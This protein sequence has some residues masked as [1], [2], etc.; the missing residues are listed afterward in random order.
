MWTGDLINPTSRP[1]F[2]RL[3]GDKEILILFLNSILPMK[4][5]DA[6]EIPSRAINK[7]KESIRSLDEP[8]SFQICEAFS[9]NTRMDFLCED[10][11]N[12]KFIV[13]LQMPY[14]ENLKKKFINRIPYYS[15][16]LLY[17]TQV[18]RGNRIPVRS[19]F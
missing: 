9:G 1:G 12:K 4:T 5:M 7:R 8:S 15:S 14:M 17:Q 6:V 2:R 16:K 11:D 13:E 3:F 18:W 10:Y 19:F